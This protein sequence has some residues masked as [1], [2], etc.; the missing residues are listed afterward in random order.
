MSCLGA[1]AALGRR[2]VLQDGAFVQAA[3]SL[4]ASPA[5]LSTVQIVQANL[6][7]RK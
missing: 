6:S 4:L 7:E 2:A 5:D 1:L 3:V